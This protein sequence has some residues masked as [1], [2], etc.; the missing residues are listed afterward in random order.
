MNCVTSEGAC[1]KINDNAV[2]TQDNLPEFAHVVEAFDRAYQKDTKV[3]CTFAHALDAKNKIA[4]AVSALDIPS[5]PSVLDIG[6]GPGII[7]YRVWSMAK[8]ISCIEP[9]HTFRQMLLSRTLPCKIRVYEEIS[10]LPR[11]RSGYDICFASWPD[12]DIRDVVAAADKHLCK[13]GMCIVALNYGG[14]AW[15]KLWPDGVRK[16]WLARIDKL[17]ALG[18]NA[19]IVQSRFRFSTA[20]ICK[21]TISYLLG[22]SAAQSVTACSLSHNIAVLWRKHL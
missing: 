11:N 13:D 10:D 16:F 6:A 21:N 20:K 12:C 14:D 9:S 18:F 4:Q 8:R 19:H 22:H 5:R 17:V 7:T 3:Y 1:S 2:F 15:E